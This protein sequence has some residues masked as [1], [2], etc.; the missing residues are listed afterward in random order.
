MQSKLGG[1][2]NNSV[3]GKGNWL[4]S[5]RSN[6]WIFNYVNGGI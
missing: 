5:Y 6:H 2:N 4:P 3:L 1:R